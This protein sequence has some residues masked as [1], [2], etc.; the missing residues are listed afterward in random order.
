MTNI[1]L[2]L[3]MPAELS[4]GIISETSNPETFGQHAQVAVQGG[5][6]ARNARQEPETKTGRAA[7]SALNTKSGMTI[8]KE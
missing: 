8:E 3:N 5:E 4:T 2:V 1:K 7:V 6:I